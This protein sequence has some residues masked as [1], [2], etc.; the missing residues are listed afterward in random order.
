MNIELRVNNIDDYDKDSLYK[1]LD[2]YKADSAIIKSPQ[3]VKEERIHNA[4]EDSPVGVAVSF[5]KEDNKMTIRPIYE[6]KS[7]ILRYKLNIE[8]LGKTVNGKIM[9]DKI[10]S[11]ILTK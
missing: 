5:N 3:L 10:K 11:L 4:A 6:F 1:A 9:V 7:N 8:C 2:Q